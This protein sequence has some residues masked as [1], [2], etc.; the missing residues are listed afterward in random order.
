MRIGRIDFFAEPFDC[1][2]G[3]WNFGIQLSLT[4]AAIM[5]WRWT[6]GVMYVPKQLR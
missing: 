5:F 4:C 3:N 6:V 1:V 2:Y